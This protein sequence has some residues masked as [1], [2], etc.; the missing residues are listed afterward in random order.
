LMP[1]CIQ[2][3]DGGG[4]AASWMKPGFSLAA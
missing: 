1:Q 4:L 2:L 3:L